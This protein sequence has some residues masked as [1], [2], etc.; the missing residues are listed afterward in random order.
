MINFPIWIPDCDSHSPAL[1]DLFLSSDSSICSTMASP[2]MGNSDHVVVSVSID[3]PSHS[4]CDGPFYCIAYDY[5][6]ADW[7]G[8]CD[9]LRDVP[10]DDLNL[11]LPLLLV[12]FLS[13]FRLKL[14]HISL[15]E[16]IR[17]K[18]HLSS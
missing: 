18:P 6:H 9:C 12:N 16:N 15:I 5:S 8:L 14:M 10:W 17:V 4:P 2:P 11:V 13:G 3:F 1:L 7:S